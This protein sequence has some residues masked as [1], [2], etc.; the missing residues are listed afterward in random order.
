MAFAGVT[1]GAGWPGV[2]RCLLRD[3]SGGGFCRLTGMPHS[4]PMSA[5]MLLAL[6]NDNKNR[7]RAC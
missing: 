7:L 3:G 6:G 1:E 4:E 5:L 2:P